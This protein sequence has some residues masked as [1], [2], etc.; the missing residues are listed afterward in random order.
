MQLAP[1]SL[2]GAASSSFRYTT[3]C[4]GVIEPDDQCEVAVTFLPETVGLAEA[5][6]RIQSDGGIAD[7]DLKGV[8]AEPKIRVSPSRVKFSKLSAGEVSE[9]RIIA[10]S[11]QGK[12]VLRLRRVILVGADADQFQILTSAACTE[13]IQPSESC[14]LELLFAPTTGGTKSADVLVE[15]NA[16]PLSVNI[17]GVSVQP[18]PKVRYRPGSL[19][20]GTQG[21]G[22]ESV[23]RTITL[24]SVGTGPLEVK[25]LRRVGPDREDFSQDN[26]CGE[27]LLPGDDCSI[28]VVFAP[29]EAGGKTAVLEIE[30]NAGMQS[31]TLSGVASGPRV[32]LRPTSL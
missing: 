6:L 14:D 5:V 26:T 21:T 9:S 28:D 32:S 7:V 27:P 30:T 11:N 24:S 8:G 22:T 23:V 12:G 10:I 1:F 19:N 29:G 25:L 13:A 17:E 16:G 2:L 4:P 31:I 15:S 20:F 3:D 18:E